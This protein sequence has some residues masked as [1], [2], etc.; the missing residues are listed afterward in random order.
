M[1][2]VCAML[3][4]IQQLLAKYQIFLQK[5][6]HQTDITFK[7]MTDKDLTGSLLEII[8]LLTINTNTVL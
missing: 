6:L 5:D 3:I 7:D 8:F 4:G 1:V 2:L